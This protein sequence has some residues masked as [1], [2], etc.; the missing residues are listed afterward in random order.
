MF[1]GIFLIFLFMEY[2]N[3]GQL[4]AVLTVEVK[5]A[6]FILLVNFMGKL[7]LFLKIGVLELFQ[8]YFSGI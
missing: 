7:S 2:R 8:V 6:V 4:A 1:H 3:P 5:A